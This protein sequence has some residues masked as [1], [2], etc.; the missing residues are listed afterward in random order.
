MESKKNKPRREPSHSTQF[1]LIG[2]IV[3]LVILLVTLI[4]KFAAIKALF[5]LD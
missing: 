1:V 2:I 5:W 4:A 3:L